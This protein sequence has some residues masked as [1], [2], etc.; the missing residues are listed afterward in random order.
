MQIHNLANVESSTKWNRKLVAVEVGV[1]M[2]I[3]VGG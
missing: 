3:E 2:A 1:E